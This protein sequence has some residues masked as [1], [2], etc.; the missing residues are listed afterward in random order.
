MWNRRRE[1]E[2]HDIHEI[3]SGTKLLFT[4]LSLKAFRHEERETQS[5][6]ADCFYIVSS[7]PNQRAAPVAHKFVWSWRKSTLFFRSRN[8]THCFF[9]SP[10]NPQPT[11]PVRDITHIPWSPIPIWDFYFDI[12]E[13]HIL[14]KR[15][16]T[17]ALMLHLTNPCTKRKVLS[18][19]KLKGKIY[20]TKSLSNYVKYCLL[21][22]ATYGSWFGWKEFDC[23]FYMVGDK[24]FIFFIQSFSFRCL[25]ESIKL[26]SY[27]YF[28]MISHIPFSDWGWVI[29]WSFNCLCLT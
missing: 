14:S 7:Q 3:G 15:A 24:V 18:L 28:L 10:P 21:W 5:F 25:L 1:S 13:W 19:S 27:C 4:F 12:S 2:I 26:V 16:W 17:P 8:S 22:N 11:L 23:C 20:K 29:W 6:Y 9:S